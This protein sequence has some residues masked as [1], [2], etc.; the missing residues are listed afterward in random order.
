MKSNTFRPL[1]EYENKMVFKE[2][3]QI[4]PKVSEV[5]KE[6]KNSFFIKPK[7]NLDINKFPLVFFINEETKKVIRNIRSKGNIESGG[8]YFGFIKEGKFFMSLEAAEFFFHLN[9]FKNSQKIVLTEQGEKAVLY[10]NDLKKSMIQRY[11]K[12]LKKEEYTILV[13]QNGEFCA[14]AVS[15]FNGYDIQEILNSSD[16]LIAKNLVDKGYY[17]RKEQ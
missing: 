11:P 13:N 5:F 2:L 9:L 8:I 10:G 3:S 12:E 4:S 1:N 14:L 15:K 6:M 16:K 7:S 17:L